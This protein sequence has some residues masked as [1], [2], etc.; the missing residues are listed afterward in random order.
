M[1]HHIYIYIEH[2]WI[3][4]VIIIIVM[5]II[6]IYIYIYIWVNYNELTASEPWKS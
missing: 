1:A 2:T 3:L 4:W 5:I 6:M